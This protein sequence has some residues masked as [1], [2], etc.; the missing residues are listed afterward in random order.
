[1]SRSRFSVGIRLA[2]LLNPRDTHRTT[3]YTSSHGKTGIFVR[4]PQTVLV[5][6]IPSSLSPYNTPGVSIQRKLERERQ[7]GPLGTPAEAFST[8]GASTSDRQRN[9]LGG[10]TGRTLPR[11]KREGLPA[12]ARCGRCHEF[13]TICSQP[14]MNTMKHKQSMSKTRCDCPIVPANG[15]LNSSLSNSL[16]IGPLGNQ[17]V[18]CSTYYQGCDSSMSGLSTH[19]RSQD[20]QF[21]LTPGCNA[22]QVSLLE[23]RE[24]CCL[25]LTKLPLLRKILEGG[26]IGRV[27]SSSVL[28]PM[29]SAFSPRFFR[30]PTCSDTS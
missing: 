15:P 26:E 16:Q 6:S 5:T 21:F 29:L 10:V 20:R 1:M 27:I 14:W 30:L 18:T 25:K 23:H 4:T 7:W 12:S 22:V 3:F 9:G 28:F 8:V 17:E 19:S 11:S 2:T 13:Q 24:M